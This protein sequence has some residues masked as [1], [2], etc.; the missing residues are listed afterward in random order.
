MAED[1]ALAEA[2]PNAQ[3]E[4]R[5]I[6]KRTT[7][8]CAICHRRA[9]PG[10]D[11]STVHWYACDNKQLCGVWLH[12]VCNALDTPCKVCGQGRVRQEFHNVAEHDYF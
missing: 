7:A 5:N 3:E 4:I 6:T 8:C 12:S 1:L 2:L 10:F 11:P 9:P